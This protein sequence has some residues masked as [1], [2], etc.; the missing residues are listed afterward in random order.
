MADLIALSGLG[1][2]PDLITLAPTIPATVFAPSMT[3]WDAQTV[4][5]TDDHAI[6]HERGT[7]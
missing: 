1:R 7:P 5:G 4:L 6:A 3:G 2:V